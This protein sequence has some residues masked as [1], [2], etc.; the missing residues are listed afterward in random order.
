MINSSLL[1]YIHKNKTVNL[2]PNLFIIRDEN[3][4]D[5]D[6]KN[7]SI[8]LDFIF[9]ERSFYEKLGD[10]SFKVNK[11]DKRIIWE[12]FYPLSE[13]PSLVRILPDLLSDAHFEN[14]HLGTVAH[15]MALDYLKENIDNIDS[16]II[17]HNGRRE[18]LLSRQKHLSAMGFEPAKAYTF[19]EY[20]KKSLEFAIKKVDYD[21]FK[22]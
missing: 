19:K 10:L 9:E 2:L 5:S 7:N 8:S 14:K 1:D 6:L 12:S 21:V 16:Y 11:K 13:E 20:Y 17:H 15:M 3:Y 22:R 4:S 18:V